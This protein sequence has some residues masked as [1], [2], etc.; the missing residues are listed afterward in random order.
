MCRWWWSRVLR[1]S[2]NVG[3]NAKWFGRSRFVRLLLLFGHTALPFITVLCSYLS[4]PALRPL[5][6]VAV[7]NWYLDH[8]SIMFLFILHH[9]S[10]QI[11]LCVLSF[12]RLET[13]GPMVPSISAPTQSAAKL[14]VP[15]VRLFGRHAVGPDRSPALS[16][17]SIYVLSRIA[18][19]NQLIGRQ[20]FVFSLV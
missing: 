4:R 2:V 19:F 15:F 10:V 9:A 16:H 14:L 11:A 20:R 17:C 13:R 18:S 7:T 1:W 3:S 6:S 12:S 5:S 8:L